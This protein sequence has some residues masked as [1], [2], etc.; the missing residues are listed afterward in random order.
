M[1]GF[2]FGAPGIIGAICGILACVASSI[3]MC[4][5]PKGVEEGNGKFI[6]VRKAHTAQP[7]RPHALC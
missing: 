2:G 5:P 4:C 7:Q 1:I 6:A 3:L